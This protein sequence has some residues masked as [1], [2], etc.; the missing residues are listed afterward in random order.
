MTVADGD[1]AALAARYGHRAVAA[2]VDMLAFADE[3]DGVIVSEGR[4]RLLSSRVLQLAAEALLQKLGEAANRLP[5]EFRDDHPHVPW[6]SIRGMRNVI[7]H[8]YDSVD[9]EILW[10]TASVS[11]PPAVEDMRRILGRG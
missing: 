1:E 11:L 4:E 5:Q 8:K 2:L 9:Y 3:I 7:A 10:Q 6:R